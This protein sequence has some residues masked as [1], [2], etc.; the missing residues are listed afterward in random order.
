MDQQNQ[1]VR[2]FL[3]SLI[4]LDLYII[5]LYYS[6]VHCF[7]R[8]FIA[9]RKLKPAP[10]HQT[11]RTEILYPSQIGHF[12]V[13]LNLIMKSRLSAKFKLGKLC[14]HSY[15]NETNFHMKCFELSLAFIMRFTATRKWPI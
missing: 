11:F 13:A 7:C 3:E 1:I 14:F 4:S 6:R 2:S 8:L 9:N 5:Q 12:R 15:A 10:S